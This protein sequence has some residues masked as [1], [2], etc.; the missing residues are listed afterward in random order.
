[1]PNQKRPARGSR[2][3]RPPALEPR[4]LRLLASPK[5]RPLT[6][7]EIAQALDGPARAEL[8]DTLQ[9]MERD[10]RIARVRKDRYILPDEADLLAGVLQIHTSGAAH[11][12]SERP[13]EPD[14]FIPAE[15]TGTAM[16]GDRVVARIMREGIE[17]RR[18]RG[19]GEK[20]DA[21]QGRVI[22]I[23]EQAH[24]T[25]VGTLQM[26]KQKFHYVIPDDPRIVHH[27]YVHPGSA[28]LPRRPEVGHKVVVKLDPWESRH[29]NPEGEIVEVL[30]PANAPGVDM[31]SII[32]KHHLP[33]D[34]PSDVLDEAAR[35]R[36]QIPRQEVERRE[37]LRDQLILTIDPD[38]AKDFDD[39]IHVEQTGNGWRLGVHIADVSHYVPSGS[40][41]DREA[42]ARGNSV[43]L[44]DRVIPML[45]ETLSNGICSLRPDEDRL[46]FSAFID[47]S[48]G[49]KIKS[50]RFGRSVI[51]SAR[52]FTYKEAFAILQK[53]PGNPIEEKLH[54][55]WALASVLRQNRFAA[56]SLDLDFPEVK[57]RLDGE[58]R[59]VRLEKVENDISHQLIEEFML[60]ANEVVA[61][62][63]KNRNVPAIYRIHEDPDAEKLADYRELALSHGYKVGDLTQRREIQ[64]LLTA[65]R[66]KPE[67][68]ALKL[69]LLKSLKRAAYATKP[70][71]HYGL[72]KVNYTHFTSPIRRYADLVVHRLLASLT[73]APR[74]APRP[75]PVALDAA[76]E[77]ISKTERTAADAEKES[78]K[79][80]KME[81]FQ[82]QL[83]ARKP[84]AHPAVIVDVRNYG[85]LVELPEFLVTGLVHVSALSDDFYMFDSARLRF[86]GK[87]NKKSYGIGDRM[88][89]IVSRV[90]VHK[91]QIDFAPAG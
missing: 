79:L 86:V 58:G 6:Q 14:L 80:K 34:F 84:E 68:F 49:G 63:L 74:K 62:E 54:T 39:A 88:P 52:R 46:V 44:V 66:G 13:G 28:T 65:V 57:V 91:Q 40:A 69:G 17:E 71:G 77:H 42:F 83:A 3:Q 5:Y 32:R 26:T 4:I 20:G 43:Y 59:P 25:I 33:V 87:R 72:A 27:V 30:G 37:D 61:R 11:L 41:L 56:G 18:R 53:R 31:L 47:F 24:S 64:R 21:S 35:V 38:D 51:R 45:P 73:D 29:V 70:V 16:N 10:G 7:G 2:S 15:H 8:A 22:R 75:A 48:S 50:A 85:L 1:M 76:A 12:L 9:R 23:L 90:D 81:Y 36:D 82:A 60:A 19:R 78:V 67:E 89:V 55:A